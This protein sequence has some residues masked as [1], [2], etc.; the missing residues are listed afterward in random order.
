M[1]ASPLLTDTRLRRNLR[2]HIGA[3]VA[4]YIGQGRAR[5]WLPGDE[6]HTYLRHWH[7]TIGELFET[8]EAAHADNQQS[9][10]QPDSFCSRGPDVC[11]G[12]AP[13]PS[14]GR[15]FGWFDDP[16]GTDSGVVSRYDGD[17]WEMT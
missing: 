12:S 13:S 6:Y 8:W 2:I 17:D 1:T 15:V 16:I 11:C 9:I 5:D 3:A 14:G 7:A 10:Q 4:S